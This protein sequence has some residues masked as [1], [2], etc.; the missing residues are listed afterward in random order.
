[1]IEGIFQIKDYGKT[2]IA[3]KD[4]LDKIGKSR[5]QLSKD[6]GMDY[7]LVTRYYNNSVNRIDLDVISRMCFVLKCDISDILIYEKPEEGE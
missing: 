7:S 5:N 6:I 3:L 2:R 4:I 1:M